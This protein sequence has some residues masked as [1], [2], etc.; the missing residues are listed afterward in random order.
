MRLLTIYMFLSLLAGGLC[1]VHANTPPVQ[2]SEIPDFVPDIS[3]TITVVNMFYVPQTSYL[4]GLSIARISGLE[5]IGFPSYLDK[6]L[7][8]YTLDGTPEGSVTLT[9][10]G[11]PHPWDMCYSANT[12]RVFIDDTASPNIFYSTDYINWHSYANPGGTNGR[13]LDWT[14]NVTL[15]DIIVEANYNGFESGVYMFTELGEVS[16]Y[17]EVADPSNY[18]TGVTVFPLNGNYYLMAMSSDIDCFYFYTTTVP[19]TLVGYADFPQNFEAYYDIA[20]C[21]SRDTVYMSG[22]NSGQYCIYELQFDFYNLGIQSKSL[23]QV[24]ALYY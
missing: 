8:Y 3:A 5:H 15:S 6:K 18:L 23:G 4:R 2:K 12:D 13:G 9:Y 20:Y 7:F 17:Y 22:K 21:S 10:S 24:R 16:D 1:P 14:E 19:I 11:N